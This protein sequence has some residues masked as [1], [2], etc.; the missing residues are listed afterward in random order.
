MSTAGDLGG[1][2]LSDPAFAAGPKDR[3]TDTIIGP[4]RFFV[5][6]VIFVVQEIGTSRVSLLIKMQNAVVNRWRAGDP[7]R[8]RYCGGSFLITLPGLVNDMPAL[9]L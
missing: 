2:V 4:R 8:V 6:L 7:A 1:R 3:P 9:P 5:F